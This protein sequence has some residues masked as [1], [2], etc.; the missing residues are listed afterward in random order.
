MT[1]RLTLAIATLASGI[2]LTLGQTNIALAQNAS[3]LGDLVGA[4]AAELALA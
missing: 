2:G 4:R 3:Q 1:S